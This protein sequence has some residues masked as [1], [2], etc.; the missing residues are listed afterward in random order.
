MRECSDGKKEGRTKVVPT[1]AALCTRTHVHSHAYT[2]GRG[3]KHAPAQI[4]V[5][6]PCATPVSCVLKYTLLSASMRHPFR[7]PEALKDVAY[8]Y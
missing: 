7:T 5:I 4:G 3:P 1:G 8:V 2:N 6:A